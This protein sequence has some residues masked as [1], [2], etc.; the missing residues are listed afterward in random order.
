MRSYCSPRKLEK[1]FECDG[2][3]AK[4]C[5]SSGCGFVIKAVNKGEVDHTQQHCSTVESMH[6]AAESSDASV[7]TEVLELTFSEKKR[8]GAKSGGSTSRSLHL[9]RGSGADVRATNEVDM[10]TRCIV[11][12]NELMK[13]AR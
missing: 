2:T 13:G 12:T 1:R 5:G 6:M 8:C 4:T 11:V 9:N 10:V 3:D 7:M